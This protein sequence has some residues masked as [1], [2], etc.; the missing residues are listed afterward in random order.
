MEWKKGS[1]VTFNKS[2]PKHFLNE[3]SKK[4]APL[5]IEVYVTSAYRSPADQAR[6]VCNNVQNTGG[7]NLSIYGSQTQEMYRTY[8]PHDMDALVAY[9]AEKLAKA[10]ERDPN[11][12]GHGTGWAVDLRVGNLA[13]EQ[14]LEYKKIIESMG[15]EVLWEKS[16]EHFHVWL[17]DYKYF[18]TFWVVGGV[19]AVAT[20]LYL[21]YEFG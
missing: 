12:Q 17:R 14:K 18:P 5:N 7:A 15:A 13:H 20:G 3:L 19:L 21:Y 4:V 11:Y 8:C 16:P 6:V 10:I 2:A 9:E 1:R